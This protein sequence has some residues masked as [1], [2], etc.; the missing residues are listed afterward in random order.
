[1]KLTSWKSSLPTAKE[2]ADKTLFHS[3]VEASRASKLSDLKYLKH[4]ANGRNSLNP[5]GRIRD[6][7]R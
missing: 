5:T 6:G 3:Q 4:E 1:M 2:L 7:R